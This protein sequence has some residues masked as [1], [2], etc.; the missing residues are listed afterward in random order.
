MKLVFFISFLALIA[1]LLQQG[2]WT[3]LGGFF[4]QT[5]IV[6][7]A[8]KLPILWDKTRL[9]LGLILSESAALYVAI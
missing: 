9:H 6:P 7:A 8:S 5:A 2:P 1:L 3:E 4:E